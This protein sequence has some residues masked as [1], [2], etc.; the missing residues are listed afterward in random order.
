M[1][2]GTREATQD[3]PKTATKPK[4]RLT[5]NMVSLPTAGTVEPAGNI[6]SAPDTPVLVTKN[7]LG[8]GAAALS[9]G[10]RAA[11]GQQQRPPPPY[12]VHAVD[13]C[14]ARDRTDEA[15]WA[16]VVDR[17][18]A[19]TVALVTNQYLL[20]TDAL[21]LLSKLCSLPLLP[22]GR[23]VVVRVVADERFPT[24]LRSAALLHRYVAKVAHG[25]LPVIAALG[26]T[27][28]SAFADSAL[29]RQVAPAVARDLGAAAEDC[30]GSEVVEDTNFNLPDNFIRPFRED[31][32]S[33]NEYKTRLECAAYNERERCFDDFSNMLRRFQAVH[34]SDV[35]GSSTT[36]FWDTEFPPVRAKVRVVWLTLTRP[37]PTPPWHPH[38][39]G[40]LTS[41]CHHVH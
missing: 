4:K 38:S 40:R 39:S 34:R 25:L 27:V 3:T 28:A 26:D 9:S 19:V 14:D 2:E 41:P 12:T 37:P 6:A 15:A 11:P 13:A 36:A 16:S 20:L 21:Q 10:G 32:D 35:D 8:D 24:A 17:M 1:W 29:L 7:M 5:P 30:K 23:G 22:P 33:R 18:G 31:I